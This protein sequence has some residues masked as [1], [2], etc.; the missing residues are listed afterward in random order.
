MKVRIELIEEHPLSADKGSRL[1]G[2]VF[3]CLRCVH[4]VKC[5]DGHPAGAVKKAEKELRR[6][7]PR[8]ES[9]TYIADEDTGRR[10]AALLVDHRS[11]KRGKSKPPSK[12]ASLKALA[13]AREAKDAELHAAWVAA[14]SE[15]GRRSKSD[16]K[17]RDAKP[18]S[19]K[20]ST[21]RRLARRKDAIKAKGVKP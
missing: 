16:A 3:R 18:L 1:Y 6:E 15:A 17:S 5:I 7:C 11:P 12:K 20:E 21:K 4:A 13:K 19:V 14:T 9:N 10:I 2:G 8:R